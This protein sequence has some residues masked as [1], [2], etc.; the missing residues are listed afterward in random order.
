MRK[1]LILFNLKRRCKPHYGVILKGPDRLHGRFPGK[2]FNHDVLE[3][4]YKG[5]VIIFNESIFKANR[6]SATNTFPALTKSLNEVSSWLRRF[7]YY[8]VSINQ[9]FC[10]AL[11]SSC[12][13]DQ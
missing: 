8:P 1:C 7:L 5:I 6:E 2:A 12:I 9:A 11:Y 13:Q 10:L 4:I 3:A